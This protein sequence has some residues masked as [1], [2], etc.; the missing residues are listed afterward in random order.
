VYRA[1]GLSQLPAA[2]LQQLHLLVGGGGDM[3]DGNPFDPQVLPLGHLTGV[4]LLE[5]RK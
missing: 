3:N 1:E 5:C 4:T 2:Q